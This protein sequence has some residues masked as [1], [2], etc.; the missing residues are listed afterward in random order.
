VSL[1]VDDADDVA[2]VGKSTGPRGVKANSRVA[3]LLMRSRSWR[4]AVVGDERV[5]S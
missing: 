2:G 4:H 5:P 1:A 3:K